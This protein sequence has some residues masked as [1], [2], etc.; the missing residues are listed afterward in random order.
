MKHIL[1][2]AEWKI[3]QKLWETAPM[4]LR[5]LQDSLSAQTGWSKHA[6]IS[7]LKRMEQKG[8]IAVNSTGSVKEYT[9][10]LQQSDAVREEM[11]QV[12]EHVGSIRLLAS[13]IVDSQVT[14]EDLDTLLASLQAA[15]DEMN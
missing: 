13:A 2:D 11:E 12:L 14:Q 6:I 8:V 3:M 5:Q 1:S 10:Q 9:P 15:R 7:F 4:T